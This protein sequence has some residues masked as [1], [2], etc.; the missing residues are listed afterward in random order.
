MYGNKNVITMIRRER[1]NKTIK[2]YDKTTGEIRE[3]EVYKVFS[4]TTK[5][6]DQFYQQYANG[7]MALMGIKPYF[8]ACVFMYICSKANNGNFFMNKL[9][10]DEVKQC[11]GL[12]ESSISKALLI[13]TEN[14]VLDRLCRGQYKINPIYAWSGTSIDRA[15]ILNNAIVTI[16]I[17]IS[18]NEEM[19]EGEGIKLVQMQEEVNKF[20]NENK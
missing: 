14:G 1:M 9:A 13:L 18:P 5:N 6:I 11:S 20:N 19:L 7:V 16:R 2:V 4:V 8:C 10:R 3:A 12:S 15:K 17:D